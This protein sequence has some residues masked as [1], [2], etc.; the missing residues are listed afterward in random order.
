MSLHPSFDGTGHSGLNGLLVIAKE[1]G[2]AIIS[3]MMLI[4][5]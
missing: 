3:G 2:K 1:N 4:H 5:N